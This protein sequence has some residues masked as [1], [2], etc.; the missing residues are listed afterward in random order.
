MHEK[1]KVGEGIVL[2]NPESYRCL[3]GKLNFLTDTR[4]YIFFAVQHLSQF[5]QKP[6]LPHIQA[7]LHLLRYLK[8]TF[9]FVVFYN[10]SPELSLSVYCDIDWWACPDKGKCVSSLCILL[11]GGSLVG[12]KSKKQFVISLSFLEVEYRSISKATAELT[13]EF[14]FK[15]K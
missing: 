14:L 4:H 12:W 15:M 8:G 6:C 9:N 5:M 1:L 13:V 3:I 10:Y 2:P 7:A 11:L